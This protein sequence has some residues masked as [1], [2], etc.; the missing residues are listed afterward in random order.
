ME[1][2]HFTLISGNKKTTTMCNVDI[3]SFE[4]HG[5]EVGCRKDKIDDTNRKRKS[6]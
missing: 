6:D 3:V 4:L 1:K 5:I 2:S